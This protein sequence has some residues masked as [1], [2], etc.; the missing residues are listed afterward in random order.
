MTLF[1]YR[2]PANYSILFISILGVLTIFLPWIEYPRIE[3]T[4]KGYHGDGYLFSIVFFFIFCMG[5]YAH[6]SQSNAPLKKVNIINTILASVLL[7]VV[8][9]K[10]I[11][12]NKEVNEYLTDNPIMGYAGSGARLDIGLYVIGIICLLIIILSGFSPIF[13][14]LKNLIILL[15]VGSVLGQ[16]IYFAKNALK[17]KLSQSEVVENL[18][19]EFDKM[20]NSLINKRPDLFANYVHP[21][22]YQSIGGKE[23]LI[24]IMREMYADINISKAEIVKILETETKGENIQSLLFQRMTIDK[25]GQPTTVTNKTFAFSYDGGIT[26]SFAGTEDRTFEQ[27]REILPEIFDE[28]AY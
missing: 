6:F 24:S 8:I 9:Q 2:K 28:L 7:C 5:L 4:L 16:G 1:E 12:F 23:K 25:N 10:M 17:P 27:M 18:A 21:I 15:I 20:G 26:W 19:T 13:S 22:L 14:K 3:Q 11:K